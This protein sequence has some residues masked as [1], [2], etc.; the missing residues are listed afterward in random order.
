MAGV[1]RI[2]TRLQKLKPKFLQMHMP[3]SESLSATPVT[4]ML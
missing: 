3:S 1:A 4:V 2:L